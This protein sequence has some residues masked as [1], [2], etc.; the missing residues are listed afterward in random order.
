MLPLVKELTEAWNPWR[1]LERV[2]R[3]FGMRDVFG[4]DAFRD[5]K[6]PI[7][8]YANE[9]CAKVFLKMPGWKAEWFDLSVENQRLVLKG[10]SQFDQKDPSTSH[11]DQAFERAVTLPFFVDPNQIKASYKDGMLSVEAARS[12]SSKPKKIEISA[13]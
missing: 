12:E 7:N 10:K 6:A 1:E 8:V 11:L 4:R 3:S 5:A 9:N 13:V 2:Q